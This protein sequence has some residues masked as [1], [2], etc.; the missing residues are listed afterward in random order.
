MRGIEGNSTPRKPYSPPYKV[1]QGDVKTNADRARADKFKKTPAYAKSIRAGYAAAPPESRRVQADKAQARVN[2]KGPKT[3]NGM[4]LR[5]TRE[6]RIVLAEHARRVNQLQAARQFRNPNNDIAADMPV[7]NSYRN[8]HPEDYP[9]PGRLQTGQTS[10]G[11]RPKSNTATRLAAQHPGIATEPDRFIA[12]VANVINNRLPVWGAGADQTGRLPGDYSK[13]GGYKDPLSQVKRV[14]GS[15]TAG[16]GQIFGALDLVSNSNN[17]LHQGGQLAGNLINSGLG[18]VGKLPAATAL[19]PGVGFLKGLAATGDVPGN[20][21]KDAVDLYA[22]ALPSLYQLGDATASAIGGDSKKLAAQ[23]EGLKSMASLQGLHDHPLLVPLMAKGGLSA[24][25]RTGGAVARSGALGASAKGF[26]STLG[27][28]AVTLPGKGTTVNRRYSHDVISKHLAQRPFDAVMG[29]SKYLQGNQAIKWENRVGDELV[30][31]GEATRRYHKT[32][33]NTMLGKVL[34]RQKGAVALVPWIARGYVTKPEAMHAELADTLAQR[35]QAHAEILAEDNPPG[36]LDRLRNNEEQQR[37]LQSLIDDQSLTPN[38]KPVQR[39]FRAAVTIARRQGVTDEHLVNLGHLNKD[40]A[41]R[42]KAFDYVFRHMAGSHDDVP[43]PTAQ[44]ILKE[45]MNAAE[46]EAR[47]AADAAGRKLDT[48]EK[49]VREEGIRHNA[50]HQRGKVPG[51]RNRPIE[52]QSRDAELKKVRR[53]ISKATNRTESAAERAG[54]ASGSARVRS[55]QHDKNLLKS[56]PQYRELRKAASQA[57][58]EKK[59]ARAA[60]ENAHGKGASMYSDADRATTQARLDRSLAADDTAQAKLHAYLDDVDAAAA[61]GTTKQ[62]AGPA[63]RRPTMSANV[64]P[65]P[66]AKGTVRLYRGEGTPAGNLPGWM[67]ENQG[68]WFTPDRAKA[69]RYG[70]LKYVDVPEGVARVSEVGPGEHVLSAEWATKAQRHGEPG[71]VVVN[72]RIS[73]TSKAEAHYSGTGRQ[74][75][76]SLRKAERENAGHLAA[77]EERARLYQHERQLTREI[78]K[79]ENHA[80]K[81]KMSDRERLRRLVEERDARKAEHEQ[82]TMQHQ[83]LAESN[84]NFRVTQ[85]EF[86]PGLVDEHGIQLSTEAINEHMIANG[87]QGGLEHIAFATDRPGV[88]GSKAGFVGAD[89]PPYEARYTRTGAAAHEG[90]GDMSMEAL[91]DSM[92]RSQGVL[93][94]LTQRRRIIDTFVMGTPEGGWYRY[95]DE[96]GKAARD[97]ATQGIDLVVYQVSD[98][99]LDNARREAQ[100]AHFDPGVNKA[101]THDNAM[102]FDPAQ[103]IVDEPAGFPDPGEFGLMSKTAAQRLRD[104]GKAIDSNAASRGF[105]EFTQKWRNAVLYGTSMPKWVTGNLAEMALRMAIAGVGPRSM[106]VG[107]KVMEETVRQDG[108]Q[109]EA[110]FIHNYLLGGAHFSGTLGRM[111]DFARRRDQ[112]STEAQLHAVM[113][114]LSHATS[115]RERLVFQAWTLYKRIINMVNKGAELG[116]AYGAIGKLTLKD[117]ESWGHLNEG[118]KE[119]LTIGPEAASQVAKGLLE[120]PEQVRY[121]RFVYSTIGRYTNLSPS[122]RHWVANYTPFGLWFANALKFNLL[123]IPRHH[124]L[125]GALLASAYLATVQD[126]EQL[127]QSLFVDGALPGFLQGSLMYEGYGPPGKSQ[128]NFSR[129]TP[130]GAFSDP[131]QTAQQ[132]LMPQISDFGLGMVGRDFKLD[133]VNLSDGTDMTF[134][135]RLLYATY[136]TAEGMVP[137][138]SVIH[139]ISAGKGKQYADS[140]LFRNRTKPG[141]RVSRGEAAKSVLLPGYG[142]KNGSKGGGPAKTG[143]IPSLPSLPTLPSIPSIGP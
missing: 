10:F 61:R 118:W 87:I 98:S 8:Q 84:K 117:R 51:G 29:R 141:T 105:Q 115:G 128:H 142:A 57:G 101:I 53:D 32:Q 19:L 65:G 12:S 96:A 83:Q 7:A 60:H 138:L 97:A 49:R 26:A 89:R 123:T 99:R 94:A 85:A 25:G 100:Q 76:A 133:R 62:A 73:P 20:A 37:V 56:D 95:A 1:S 113:H 23:W 74:P 9:G 77:R 114:R 135:K 119:S 35:K 30:G 48:A 79:L 64:E 82:A 110:A 33:I 72:S 15:G 39:A 136:T 22:Q 59:D 125:F 139:Q 46:H 102:T 81:L 17:I 143:G 104:H 67:A 121:A 21:F 127:K 78:K 116:G 34:P 14:D 137:F 109:Q 50:I 18:E 69:A 124:P 140:Y 107:W 92:L 41:E 111:I 5:A 103:G 71:K 88:L 27:R 75:H 42:S 91:A 134:D 2:L 13:A 55:I 43:R 63:G 11:V 52:L 120:T 86:T 45:G 90:T 126:R 16:I 54:H 93:D 24:V 108:R 28:D 66:P 4:D 6:D 3:F 129:Y 132:Q 80:D 40:Q 130:F 68:K 122:A 36:K 70:N 47:K 131:G 112:G 38:S 106:I 58:K 31:G 44:A